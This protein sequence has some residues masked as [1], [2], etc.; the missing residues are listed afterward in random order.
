[1]KCLTCKRFQIDNAP[2]AN[3]RVIAQLYNYEGNEVYSVE[4]GAALVPVWTQT[5]CKHP[6]RRS[7]E[8]DQREGADRDGP[9]GGH[10]SLGTPIRPPKSDFPSHR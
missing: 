2:L 1:M 6:P 9:T 5:G 8:A 4:E 3:R 7:R 10:G